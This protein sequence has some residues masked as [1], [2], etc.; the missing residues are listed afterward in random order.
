[1][2]IPITAPITIDK[3]MFFSNKIDASKPIPAKNTKNKPMNVYESLF[4]LINLS[5]YLFGISTT[6]TNSLLTFLN[7]M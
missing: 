6:R 7:V 1:M 3:G 4:I 5:S 2:I